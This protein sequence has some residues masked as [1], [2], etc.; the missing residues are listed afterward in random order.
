[1]RYCTVAL[2]LL[3]IG[4][5]LT[6]QVPTG[7][8][9]SGAQTYT[10]RPGDL[11]RITVWG[12]EDFSGQFQVDENGRIVYPVVG[13]IDT[14]DRTVADLREE[15]RA[16]L[17]QI[18]NQPF[19]TITPLFRIAVLGHVRQPGLLTIDP[20]LTVLDVVALAGGPD[21]VGNLNGIKLFRGGE[22]L[23]LRFE[24]DRVG[25]RT[26]QDVG[27]RSGDQITVPRRFFTTQDALLLL[28]L[29]QV[30]LSIAILI[31]AF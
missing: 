26:L 1:M 12:Q 20:T 11:V 7:I 2:L 27:I 19:V 16:G 10:L 21:N 22:E 24:R 29:L 3:S 6:A 9:S 4:S 15:L 30:G 8:V 14:R 28:Q 25:A 13:E 23:N 18:F 5:P 17:G 31:K